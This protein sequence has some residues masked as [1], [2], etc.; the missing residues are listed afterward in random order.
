M[1]THQELPTDMQSSDR[2]KIWK[3][4][5]FSIKPVAAIKTLTGTVEN[6][7]KKLLFPEDIK[8]SIASAKPK[9]ERIVIMYF[10]G[11]KR[12]H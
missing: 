12:Q 10:N 1:I 2:L 4:I 7:V 3:C 11:H 5:P 9:S 8:E 6:Y